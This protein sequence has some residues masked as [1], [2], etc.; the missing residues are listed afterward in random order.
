M[1]VND[2]FFS[3][4]SDY[5]GSVDDRKKKYLVATESYSDSLSVQDMEKTKLTE[6]G[7]TGSLN[8]MWSQYLVA[9]GGT[10]LSSM[11]T[12]LSTTFYGTGA[13][14]YTAYAA[15]GVTPDTFADF[16][17]ASELIVLNGTEVSHDTALTFARTGNAGQFSDSG[18]FSVVA[19]RRA[20]HIYSGSSWLPRQLIEPAA[21]T[22]SIPNSR[23]FNSWASSSLSATA[24]DQVGIDGV[25]NTAWTLTDNGGTGENCYE[26]ITVSND[27]A[28]HTVAGFVK[29]TVG[30]TVFPALR[31]DLLNGTA[32]EAELHINTNTGAVAFDSGK[33]DG[34]NANVEDCEDFWRVSFTVTNN[35][36]GNTELRVRVMAAICSTI[37]TRNTSLTGSS[38]WDQ[39]DC[40]LNTS[41]VSSPIPTAGTPVQRNAETYALTDKTGFI[42]GTDTGLSGAFK[43]LV[44]G[45]GI[46]MDIRVDVNNR[47][48]LT[49]DSGGT[50]TLTVVSGGS[51]TTATTANNVTV[52]V[53]VEVNCAWYV[54]ADGNFI[55]VSLAG[56][57]ADTTAFTDAIPDLSTADVDFD[58]GPIVNI[59]L[60]R[61]WGSSIG[62]AGIEDA[63]GWARA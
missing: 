17:A 4:L 15:N 25:S 7:Y 5:D 20:N 23:D 42:T 6:L 61:F 49:L 57:S 60:V 32:L 54:D 1:T 13:D 9:L 12:L 10:G 48:A 41:V 33:N 37:G 45:S 24:Q 56:G 14:P 3:V 21:A 46:L 35:S 31:V 62:T 47:I 2:S 58:Q 40:F 55:G 16:G 29:K 36:S 11:A 8:D 44:T 38:V 26:S 19:V 34:A 39:I 51:T 53:N 30:A 63:D 28:T 22:N 43:G 27:G 52:G 18:V 50:V 59:E